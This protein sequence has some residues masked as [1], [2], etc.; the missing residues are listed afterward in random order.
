MNGMLHQSRRHAARAVMLLALL[1]F[2][3][4]S[5]WA[6]DRP[7]VLVIATGGTIASTASGPGLTGDALVSA[8]PALGKVARLQVEDLA[9]GGSSGLKRAD[10]ARLVRRIRAAFAGDPTLAG[11]VVTHGTDTLEETAMLLDLV[12]ADARPVVLTG[13]MRSSDEISADGPANLLE[14]VRVAA[15]PQARGRGTLVALDGQILAAGDA[16]KLSTSRTSAFASPNQG[17]LGAVIEDGVRFFQPAGRAGRVYDLSPERIATLPRVDIVLS[18]FDGDG[19]LADA[20]VAAGAKG[21]V[22]AGFGSGTLAPPM[23]ST[24]KALA[25]SGFPVVLSARVASGAV[26]DSGL[27]DGKAPAAFARSGFLNPAKARVLLMVH[28]AAGGTETLQAAFAGR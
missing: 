21:L 23:R 5:A 22:V 13:S 9:A 3:A 1:L 28:L 18:Y 14:A 24:V 4:N 15:D 12:I 11:I 25:E 19:A 10:W 6:Q 26:K 2:S 20:A 17:A 16:A 7:H 8:I 27:W